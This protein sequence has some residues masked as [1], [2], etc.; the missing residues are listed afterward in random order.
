MANA[1]FPQRPLPVSLPKPTSRIVAFLLALVLL[2]VTGGLGYLFG[3]DLARDFGMRDGTEPAAAARIASGKCRS[4]LI[5]HLCDVTIEQR[6]S[7][8]AVRTES[9]LAFVDLHFGSY[10][11]SVVQARGNPA[12]VTTSLGMDYLWNRV[13][14]GLAGFGGLGLLSLMSVREAFRSK[15]NINTPFKA[16]HNTILT[17]V[18]ADVHGHEDQGT[19]GRIWRYAPSGPQLGNELAVMLPAGAWPFVLNAEGTK[20]LAVTGRPGSP[21][22]LLDDQLAVIGLSDDERHAIFAWR[23]ALMEKAAAAMAPAPQPA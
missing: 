23:A 1:I 7:G 2:A 19:K 21:A 11:S 3:P 14:T 9:H 15:G 6:A 16:L 5:F 8:G 4:K 20:A 18:I 12:S 10:T 13:L 22:M 17:P